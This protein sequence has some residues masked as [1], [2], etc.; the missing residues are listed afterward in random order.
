MTSTANTFL[1]F[2][3][4]VTAVVSGIQLATSIFDKDKSDVLELRTIT[5]DGTDPTA[6]IELLACQARSWVGAVEAMAVA[7]CHFINPVVCMITD[8]V[9]A[10][11]I[12]LG[13]GGYW[14]VY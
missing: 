10:I 3:L 9:V 4:P 11:Q 2:Q 7:V 6:V 13:P 1:Q 14:N 8:Y 12:S 5:I